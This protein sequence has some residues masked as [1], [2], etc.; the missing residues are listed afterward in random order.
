MDFSEVRHS[1]ILCI[2]L[3]L[4][5]SVY[6]N[7]ENATHSHRPGASTTRYFLSVRTQPST[8]SR[9]GAPGTG[10]T[11]WPRGSLL[12]ASGPFVFFFFFPT[13][14]GTGGSYF[15]FLS[16]GF[17]NG[18]GKK[19]IREIILKPKR[20]SAGPSS[21]YRWYNFPFRMLLKT[22]LKKKIN[23]KICFSF[24]QFLCVNIIIFFF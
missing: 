15:F 24:F 2:L 18:I 19:K 7:R 9:G 1:C 21:I 22:V 10:A 23:K 8:L 17:Q 13:R 20:S 6:S 14:V 4:K 3:K 16:L 11:S 5:H 12:A